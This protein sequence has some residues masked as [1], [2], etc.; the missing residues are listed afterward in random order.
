MHYF[1]DGHPTFFRG[2]DAE[3]LFG[4]GQKYKISSLLP[5]RPRELEKRDV[6]D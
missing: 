3:D 1:R 5:L 6:L 4:S 2:Y